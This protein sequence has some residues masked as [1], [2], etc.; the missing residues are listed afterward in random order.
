MHST[1]IKIVVFVCLKCSATCVISSFC[2]DVD[3]ICTLLGNYAV[4][5]VIS[6]RHVRTTWILN[7]SRLDRKVVLK[8][9]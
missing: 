8:S 2:C 5:G 4:S 9:R 6:Y 1:C 7:P 3:E